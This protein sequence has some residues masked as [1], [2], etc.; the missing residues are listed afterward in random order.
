MHTSSCSVLYEIRNHFVVAIVQSQ[1]VL[2]SNVLLYAK[3]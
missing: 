1:L 3:V 2:I